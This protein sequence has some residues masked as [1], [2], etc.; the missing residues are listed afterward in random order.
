LNLKDG[1]HQVVVGLRPGSAS[2]AKAEA[3]GVKVMDTAE[4][5]A[6]GDVVMMLVPDELAPETYDREVAPGLRAGRHFAVAHGFSIHFRKIVPPQDVNVF[7]VA[8][9]APGHLL[10]HE[11]TK[12]AGVPMLMAV[13][14]DPSGDTRAVALA[15]ACAIGGGRA[16]VIETTFKD[17]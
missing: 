1:G 14:Q 3:S 13:H 15:Y 16:G 10:R 7:M 4:A 9:K 17:E 12:G 6:W 5:V 8:P 2:R 11:F